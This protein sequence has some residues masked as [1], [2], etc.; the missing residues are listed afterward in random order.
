[1]T[2]KIVVNQ[3]DI[4]RFMIVHQDPNLGMERFFG[5]FKNIT[6]DPGTD[7]ESQEYGIENW[8]ENPEYGAMAFK[9]PSEA[10]EYLDILPEEVASSC[11]IVLF[12][13]SEVENTFYGSRWYPLKECDRNVLNSELR[14][15]P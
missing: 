5:G 1:M 13:R 15:R 14:V 9:S 12:G 8:V 2:D 4:S 6:K 3:N 7:D 10:K 11:R